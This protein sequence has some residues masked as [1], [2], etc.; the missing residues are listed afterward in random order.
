MHICRSCVAYKSRKFCEYFIQN[1]WFCPKYF[2]PSVPSYRLSQKIIC[3]C[4]T[5]SVISLENKAECFFL[6]LWCHGKL[7][8][9]FVRNEYFGFLS[10][11]RICSG[12]LGNQQ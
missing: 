5:L 11:L 10:L 8:Q 1:V 9:K 7:L 4:H 6:R 2:N 3:W 12:R